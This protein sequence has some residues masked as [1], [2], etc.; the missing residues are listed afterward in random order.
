M[1]PTHPSKPTEG[2]YTYQ[3]WLSTFAKLF[4][5]NKGFLSE[6][7]MNQFPESQQSKTAE[8][9]GDGPHIIGFKID[10]QFI[11]D[12]RECEFDIANLEVVL[13]TAE[14]DKIEDNEAKFIEEI[15]TTACEDSHIIGFK[16]D[17]RRVI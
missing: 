7:Q 4:N 11:Y 9:H 1:N 12:H 17:I 13:P 16:I 5:I 6:S 15:A 2:D 3:I 14:E 8:S 10:I